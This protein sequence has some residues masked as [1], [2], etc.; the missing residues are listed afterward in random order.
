M[1]W[2]QHPNRQPMPP[3]WEAIRQATMLRA[4]GR[5]EAQGSAWPWP[6]ASWIGSDGRCV[7]PGTDA[8]H[9]V[10]RASS[11]SDETGAETQWLCSYH[12]Q[13]KTGTE[14]AAARAEQRKKL[15]MPTEKPPGLL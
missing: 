13:W 2:D 7:M 12:H 4:G 8:D 1:T 15:R 11:V 10:N 9:I 5:C 3:N 6:A 14:A